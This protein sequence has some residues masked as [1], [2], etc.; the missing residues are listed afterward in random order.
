VNW[1]IFAGIAQM[2]SGFG[3]IVIVFAFLPS[4]GKDA[5]ELNLGPIKLSIYRP[6]AFSSGALLFGVGLILVGSVSL[7]ERVV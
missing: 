6:A 2:V 5:K 3:L 1:N 4:R 7:I